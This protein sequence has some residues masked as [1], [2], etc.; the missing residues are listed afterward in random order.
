M[1]IALVSLFPEMFD[2]V[3]D[4]GVTGRAVKQGLVEI[5]HSNPRDFTSDRHRTVDDRPY[6]GGPGMLMKIDPLQQAIAAAREKAGKDAKVIYLSPQGKRLDHGKA[7]ELSREQALILVAGRYEGVDERLIEAEVDEEIS[8]G[9]YVL[10]GGELAA[11]VVIDTVTRQL[12]GVLGHELSAQE[13]SYADG[14]LDCPHYTRPEEY[15]GKLV[16]E[17]LLSGNHEQIRRWRLKQALGRTQER[18]PDLLQGRS[19]TA[20]EEALLAEYLR[21]RE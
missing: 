20:E 14:L 11:M 18:R 16:P 8:I 3:S 15:Q 4:H 21:E 10:S 6:G 7:V 12:P 13:D 9:D 17:V 1:H 2:A 19:M 5:S